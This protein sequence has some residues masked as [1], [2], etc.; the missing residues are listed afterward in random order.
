MKRSGIYELQL[1]KWTPY[2]K[3]DRN[4]ESERLSNGQK[5]NW[6]RFAEKSTRWSKSTNRFTESTELTHRVDSAELA[7]GRRVTGVGNRRRLTGKLPSGDGGGDFRRRPSC[8]GER[9]RKRRRR[10]PAVARAFH[11][12]AK[13]CLLEARERLSGLRSRRGWCLR[14]CLDERNTMMALDA[15]AAV[16]GDD[17]LDDVLACGG[18]SEDSWYKGVGRVDGELG[19]ATSQLDQLVYEFIQLV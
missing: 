5:R 3:S 15:R 6:S 19:K 11:A 8:G 17:E 10:F 4:F 1:L 2:L 18:S 13:G 7:T 9:R 12:R 16:D 14:L